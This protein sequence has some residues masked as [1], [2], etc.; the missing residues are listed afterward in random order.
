MGVLVVG[1]GR[2]GRERG[3]WWFGGV[4][5][6]VRGGLRCSRFPICL[7]GRFRLISLRLCLGRNWVDDG[8]NL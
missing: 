7:A 2:V 1:L 6:C 8:M 5:G 4:G 3:V